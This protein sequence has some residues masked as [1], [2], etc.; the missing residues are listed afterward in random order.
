MRVYG[1]NFSSARYDYEVDFCI[2]HPLVVQFILWPNELLMATFRYLWAATSCTKASPS[3][4]KN[5]PLSLCV[6]CNVV[7]KDIMVSVQLFRLPVNIAQLEYD[8]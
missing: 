4:Q 7:V 5:T 8:M 6:A 3:I 1:L 2:I